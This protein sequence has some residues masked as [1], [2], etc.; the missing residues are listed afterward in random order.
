[1]ILSG[2]AIVAYLL[3]SAGAAHADGR[4]PAAPLAAVTGS[5]DSGPGVVRTAGETV[6]KATPVR[7]ATDTVRHA[8]HRPAPI[9][10]SASVRS[11]ASSSK[12]AEPVRKTTATRTTAHQISAR[13]PIRATGRTAHPTVRAVHATGRTIRST[14]RAIRATG[15]TVRSTDDARRPVRKVVRATV[16]QPAP[17]VRERTMSA[18]RRHAGGPVARVHRPA[19]L[20]STL[21]R[22]TERVTTRLSPVTKPVLGPA[23]RGVVGT[24][25][26]VVVR[27][28]TRTVVRPVV[29]L[30][31]RPAAETATE[32]VL[33]PM[34]RTVVGP[35][36]ETAVPPVP[37]PAGRTGTPT[38][39]PGIGVAPVHLPAAPRP[40][41]RHARAPAL[42]PAA[43][44]PRQTKPPAV[45]AAGEQ[46][47]TC[48]DSATT[49]RENRSGPRGDRTGEPGSVPAPPHAPGV[50]AP[51]MS[52]VS[53]SGGS[54]AGAGGW[55]TTSSAWR[56]ALRPAGLLVHT[57]EG[58]HGRR[59]TLALPPG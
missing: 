25:V 15:T 8:V 38:A 29:E 10:S 33:R 50:P 17:V 3:F 7:A 40:G 45:Q 56:P 44:A 32:V 14:G 23:V 27:P 6:R 48:D 11:S 57:S 28:A 31:V 13:K 51:G 22:A 52:P 35:V 54:P 43:S 2:L 34:T 46:T 49:T 47:L 36:V 18:V 41:V 9:R 58:G 55:A 53:A 12:R 42:P 26:D 39:S 24:A 1:M 5:G 16:R 4:S 30:I 59:L 21:D 37:L 19:P 20:R